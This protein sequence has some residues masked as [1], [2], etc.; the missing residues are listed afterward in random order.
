MDIWNKRVGLM[1]ILLTLFRSNVCWA[2]PNHAFFYCQ[3]SFA[4]FFQPAIAMRRVEVIQTGLALACACERRAHS[5]NRVFRKPLLLCCFFEAI[6]NAPTGSAGRTRRE[7]QGSDVLC[8][9]SAS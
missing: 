7:V 1:S 5:C 4:I 8:R 9:L 2:K 6:K 3:H